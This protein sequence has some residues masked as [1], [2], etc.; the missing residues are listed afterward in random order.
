[1][2]WTAVGYI[3][4][5]LL[6]AGILSG[7][8]GFFIRDI[9]LRKK[10]R[11]A[12]VEW[13]EHMRAQL[14][15]RDEKLLALQTELTEAKAAQQQVV[16]QNNDAQIAELQANHTKQLK[17]LE[18]RASESTQPLVNALNE[19]RTRVNH[20]LDEIARRD[21]AIDLLQLD[22]RALRE[23]ISELKK[24]VH[25]DPALAVVELPQEA[26]EDLVRDH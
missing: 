7:L 1:M 13:E 24:L 18:K 9:T 15:P 21:E 14:K 2:N 16:V 19:S 22:Q 17:E 11:R 8:I 26:S 23:Q 10:W 5:H 12:E 20:L 3:F 25:D 6:I 4:F